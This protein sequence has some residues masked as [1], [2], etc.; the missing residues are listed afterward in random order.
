MAK[1]AVRK[2]LRAFLCSLAMKRTLMSIALAIVALISLAAFTMYKGA[3]L[4][5]SEANYLRQHPCP[6]SMP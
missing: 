4:G 3:L 5:G 2:N 1:W 6:T